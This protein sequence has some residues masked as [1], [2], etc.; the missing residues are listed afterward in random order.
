LVKVTEDKG[1]VLWSTWREV[2]SGVPARG[3]VLGPLLFLYL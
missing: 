2:W 3:S 1:F